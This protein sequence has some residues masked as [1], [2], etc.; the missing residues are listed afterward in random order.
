[1]NNAGLINGVMLGLLDRFLDGF[2]LGL[3]NGVLFGLLDRS[4]DRI[5][6]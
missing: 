1:M 4:L 2:S 3:L 6:L 5:S